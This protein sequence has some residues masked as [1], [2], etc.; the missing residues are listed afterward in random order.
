ML[1]SQGKCEKA[2]EH[3]FGL[4]DVTDSSMVKQNAFSNAAVSAAFP[5]IGF[6]AAGLTLT[7]S[8]GDVT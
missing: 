4:T 2:F 5:C 7:V 3:T 6:A 1:L 8:K